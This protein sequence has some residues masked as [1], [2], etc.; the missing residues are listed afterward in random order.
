MPVLAERSIHNENH[1]MPLTSYPHVEA[2]R[3][4]AARLTTHGH[5]A[6][7]AGGAVRDL[8]LGVEPRDA[9]V[10][11][12]ARPEEIVQLYKGAKLVGASFGV[13]LVPVGDFWIEV[14]AFRR[15][16]PYLDGR[17][18]SS[19]EPASEEEDAR[20]RDFTVNG[21]FMDPA[22]DQIFDY[23]GGRADLEARILRAIG[24]P[25]AR[26]REDHLRLLRAVRLA[27]QLGFAIEPATLDALRRMAPLA[28]N[29]AAER[30]RDELVRIL[31][32]ADPARALELLRD[33]GLLQALLPEIA[34][35]R[36][37]EQSPEHHPEGDVLTHTILLFRHLASPSPELAF[38]ALLHDVG[39]PITFER[40]PDRI[41][42]PMHEKI[43]AQMASEIT[44]RLRFSNESTERIAELVENHMRFQNV[45][46]MRLSTLKRFLAMPQFEEHLALHRADCLAS[47]GNLDFYEFARSKLEELG[48]EE[49]RPPRLVTGDDLL[50]LG[51]QEGPEIGRELRRLEEMQLEGSIRTRDEAV[52]QAI[53][54][55]STA[56]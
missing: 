41:R 4:V 28:A 6:L 30:T 51:Y 19:V 42:F 56:S 9:D 2:A 35:M 29:V 1:R 24:D 16:G 49:I 12:S 33:T 17:R 18:P 34:A 22:S 13:I 53:R 26:F 48:Q 21:L 44:R 45:R 43:G 15:E 20:R 36:G 39:K 5:R 25:E 32:G 40:G 46:E 55:L 37:V 10:A 3:T 47:H 52:D 11:T 7:L 27:A 31:T 14:T 50:Q 8:L 38:A 23:V 54:D